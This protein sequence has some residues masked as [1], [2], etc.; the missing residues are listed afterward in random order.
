VIGFT[1]YKTWK[2][3]R[4]RYGIHT[5]LLGTTNDFQR[6]NEANNKMTALKINTFKLQA[7]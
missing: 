2:F 1:R 5:T 7:A 3:I 4:Q 6:Y